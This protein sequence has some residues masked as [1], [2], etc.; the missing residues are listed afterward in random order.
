MH[1]DDDMYSRSHN[2]EGD[3]TEAEAASATQKRARK[4]R[5]RAELTSGVEVEEADMDG[6]RKQRGSGLVQTCAQYEK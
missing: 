2:A 6:K 4:K 5:I 1:V 3:T